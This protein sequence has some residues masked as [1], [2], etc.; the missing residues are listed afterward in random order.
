[1]SRTAPATKPKVGIEATFTDIIA[2]VRPEEVVQTDSNQ[3][4]LEDYQILLASSIAGLA[5]GFF[6]G[7]VVVQLQD[8]EEFDET[9]SKKKFLSSDKLKKLK[10]WKKH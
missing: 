7:Y 5:I 8:T 6:S 3:W 10:F 2:D 9:T 1:M 4:T